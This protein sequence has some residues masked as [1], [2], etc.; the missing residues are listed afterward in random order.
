MKIARDGVTIYFETCEPT[1]M[2]NQP[3]INVKERARVRE[4]ID[5]VDKVLHCRY[6]LRTDLDI[7]YLV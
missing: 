5:K 7:K 3:P 2:E 1:Y 6:M 4:K